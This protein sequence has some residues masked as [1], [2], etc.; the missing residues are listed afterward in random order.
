MRDARKSQEE[1]KEEFKT[2][3]E[4]FKDLVDVEGGRLE[5]K[6]ETLNRELER[7]EDRAKQVHDRIHAV[8][9]VSNDLF[10]EWQN[11]LGKYS[12]RT[13]RAESERDLRETKRRAETL[14]AAMERAE[15]RITPVLKPMRDRVLFLKHNLNA[16]AIGSLNK[17]LV[18]VR[19]NVDS[20][21][22]E[23]ER[24]IKEADDFI[25]EMNA[26]DGKAG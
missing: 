25:K 3:L 2:A 4:K 5:E 14:I 21:V 18:S 15:D 20:L 7:S 26:E 17:E 1:A 12:D 16:R 22:A 10:K 23:L 19:G 6:Y 9:Q 11:E 24:S 13:L 8:R